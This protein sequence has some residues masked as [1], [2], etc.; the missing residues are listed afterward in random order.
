VI[1]A[2]TFGRGDGVVTS[3]VEASRGDN[4][5]GWHPGHAIA[6]RGTNRGARASQRFSAPPDLSR[7]I[8]KEDY[9]SRQQ[10][11][12]VENPAGPPSRTQR[13]KGAGQSS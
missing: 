11:P 6:D 4:G 10:I 3:P 12:L 1:P 7:S 5:R 13:V 8:A 9:E 2:R